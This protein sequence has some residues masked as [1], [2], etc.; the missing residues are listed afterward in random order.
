MKSFEIL[1]FNNR[2]PLSY[3]CSTIHE[4]YGCLEQ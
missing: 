2:Y 1:L 3:K 4:A